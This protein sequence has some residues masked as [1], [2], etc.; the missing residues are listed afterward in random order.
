MRFDL[1]IKTHERER[2]QEVEQAVIRKVVSTFRQHA[3][4]GREWYHKRRRKGFPVSPMFC[5]G[6][7]GG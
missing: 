4:D 1:T 5:K 6:L 7:T 2:F 3:L